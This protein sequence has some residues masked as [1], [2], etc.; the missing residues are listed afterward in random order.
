[1]GKEK[2]LVTGWQL[3]KTK[4]GG[5]RRERI[6]QTQ[7]AEDGDMQKN[8]SVKPD[9]TW[10]KAEEKETGRERLKTK[11]APKRKYGKK[12]TL[13]DVETGGKKR[14]TLKKWGAQHEKKRRKN[15]L[16]KKGGG[17]KLVISA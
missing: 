16:K 6:T 14:H 1:M 10:V 8:V 7:K 4:Q 15:S 17:E 2:E 12:K 5:D 3:S 13:C 11:N 9:K